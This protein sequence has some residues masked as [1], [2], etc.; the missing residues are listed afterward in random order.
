MLVYATVGDMIISTGVNVKITKY[1]IEEIK[2]I[3]RYLA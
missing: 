3:R 2:I 1:E